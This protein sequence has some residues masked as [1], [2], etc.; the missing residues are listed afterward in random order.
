MFEG[1]KWFLIP[2]NVSPQA[3]WAAEDVDPALVN[4]YSNTN[5]ST[6]KFSGCLPFIFR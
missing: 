5:A 3:L 6:L 2:S 1:H 4:H